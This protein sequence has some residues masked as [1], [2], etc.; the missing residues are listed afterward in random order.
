M[1][2]GERKGKDHKQ[3][4]ETCRE[5]QGGSGTAKGGREVENKGGKSRNI[6]GGE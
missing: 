3:G 1:K 4:R 2:E 5:K 6:D